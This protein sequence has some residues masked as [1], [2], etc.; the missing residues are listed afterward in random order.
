VRL[1]IVPLDPSLHDR[2]AFSCGIAR[3]DR[4]LQVTAAQA[5]RHLRSATFVL[6]DSNAHQQIAGFYTLAQHA[7]RD[8]ELHETVARGLRVSGLENIPMILLGRL[9]VA[10]NFQAKGLGAFLLKNALERALGVAQEAGGVALI[11]DPYN[12]NAETFYAKYGFKPL[13]REPFTRMM[14]PLRT[15]AR[16]LLA[17]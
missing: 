4:F 2:A 11:T 9:A 14:L 15:L 6:S 17:K 12:D 8:G 5:A 1:R 7:Y 16:A 13:H 3:I 10:S